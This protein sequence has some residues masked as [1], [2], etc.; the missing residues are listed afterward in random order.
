[1]G[2]IAVGA[3]SFGVS[4]EDAVKLL[5]E[6]GHTVVKNPYGRK[7][8]VQETIEHLEGAVGL[9][10]GLEQLDGEVFRNAPELKAV[11][12]I[13]IGTDNVNFEDAK[14]YNIRVSNTP[15]APTYAVAEMTLAALLSVARRV[16]PANE[17]THARMW[18]KQLGFSIRGS[19]ILLIG[20]GRIARTFAEL[21]KPF[22]AEILVHDNAVFEN[23]GTLEELLPKAGVISLH[24]SGKDAILSQNEFSYIKKGA[25]LLNS[26]RG[27]L[28]DET[29]LISALKDG[30]LSFYWG[31][32]FSSEPYD[33]E[34]CDLKNAVLTPHISTYTKSCREDMELQAARNL[35]KDLEL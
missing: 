15:E 26:A 21:L 8:T 30:T 13:G 27:T 12:R 14:K 11:A 16:I 7:L 5:E 28:V 20:Y 3:S 34:L 18:K 4:N 1:M 6:H 19:V 2:K 31:D 24:A 22:G 32:V 9:L 35:L 25:V 23:N 29:A 10:A 33:G 17:N